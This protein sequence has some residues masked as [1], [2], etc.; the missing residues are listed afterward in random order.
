[1]N[2]GSQQVARDMTLAGVGDQIFVDPL[3][4][5]TAKLH[6]LLWSLTGQVL[7]KL[8][9]LGGPHRYS[10]SWSKNKILSTSLDLTLT[11]GGFACFWG[12]MSSLR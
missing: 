10:E 1:M 11:T 12:L 5:L 9:D 2:L 4:F 8:R 3:A 7:S 6:S